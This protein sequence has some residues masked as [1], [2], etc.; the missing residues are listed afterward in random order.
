M[1]QIG[2]ASES[3]GIPEE[4]IVDDNKYNSPSD[5]ANGLNNYF[6]TIGERLKTT[7]ETSSTSENC[8]IQT[9]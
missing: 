1:K 6:A 3:S 8:D 9:K 4:L 5:I 2:N 7:R